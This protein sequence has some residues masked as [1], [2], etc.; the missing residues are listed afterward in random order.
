MKRVKL[1][2]LPTEETPVASG[3]G[4]G[5]DRAAKLGLRVDE[6]TPEVAQRLKLPDN[7]KGS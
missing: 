7:L 5:D 1:G 3:A 4:Q 2:E 6:I